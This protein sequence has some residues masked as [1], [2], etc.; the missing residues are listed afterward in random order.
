MKLFQSALK[1]HSEGPD[2]Y[3]LAAKAYEEL[4]KSE[5]FTYPDSLPE[6]R[7]DEVIGVE[8]D[9]NWPTFEVAESLDQNAPLSEYTPNTLPQVIH[10][11]RKN[12]G[13]F[14]LDV[15]E[16]KYK[17]GHVDIPTCHQLSAELTAPLKSFEEAISK[18]EA[19]VD[20]WRRIS[21]LGEHI[22]SQRLTRL[23]LE[24]IIDENGQSRSGFQI[25]PGPEKWYANEKLGD[26]WLSIHR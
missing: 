7:R 5:I 17:S 14:L 2:S 6:S 20:L 12:Y 13:Q 15:L 4:F 3:D 21:I 11:S 26:V 24:A 1:L 23:S 10:L 16:H 19:D 25:L 22:R 9:E 8:S 18:D